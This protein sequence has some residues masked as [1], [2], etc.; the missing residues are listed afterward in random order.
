MRYALPA[1]CLAIGTALATLPGPATAEGSIPFVDKLTLRVGESAV[2]HGIRGD[3]GKLP[4][5]SQLK[6]RKLKIGTLTIGRE[7]TRS[8]RRC[9]GLTPA[10]EVIFTATAPGKETFTVEGDRMRVTVTE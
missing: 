8:S 9:G 7:G 10:V 2:I 6:P 3:C 5:K 4:A 1:L